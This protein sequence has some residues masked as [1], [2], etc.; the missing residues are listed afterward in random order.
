MI[1]SSTKTCIR[2]LT[3]ILW[4]IKNILQD[5]V[6]HIHF[7]ASPCAGQKQTGSDQSPLQHPSILHGISSQTLNTS[8]LLCI[9]YATTRHRVIKILS[10]IN[11]Y[12]G[13]LGWQ[14][15]CHKL[16]KATLLLPRKEYSLTIDLG[17]YIR[18]HTRQGY[19]QRNK[20]RSRAE[21]YKEWDTYE[22]GSAY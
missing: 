13:V 18:C 21:T 3:C 7:F 19:H 9:I 5:I 10:C 4:G 15:L 16:A 14:E 17:S 8:D 22:S 20:R 1:C 6:N 2:T 12:H 11:S